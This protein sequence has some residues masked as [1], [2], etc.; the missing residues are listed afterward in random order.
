MPG[1]NLP[2]TQRIQQMNAQMRSEYTQVLLLHL[3]RFI[4]KPNT[5]I[6]L[7]NCHWFD[8]ASWSLTVSAIQQL[9]GCLVILALRKMGDKVPFELNQIL[10]YHKTKKFQL[11]NL[12]EQ[13]TNL[14][15]KQ[16]TIYYYFWVTP[17][18]RFF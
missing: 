2:E 18:N 6:I 8:S 5:V 11:S 13:D 1:L 7:E 15:I 3:L 9:S 14:L 17:I 12:T 10:H 16:V 4:A